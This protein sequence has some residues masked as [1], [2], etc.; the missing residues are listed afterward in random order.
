[1]PDRLLRLGPL[2]CLWL[3]GCA[4][5]LPTEDAPI[6]CN[7]CE[8]WSRPQAPFHIFGNTY[9][10]GTGGLSSILITTSDGLVLLDGGLPQS[11]RQIASSIRR[12]GFD[13]RDVRIIA[14]SHA[15]FDHVG[16]VAALQRFSDAAVITS[17]P[18][19]PTLRRGHLDADDPQHDPVNPTTVFPAVPN[20]QTIADGDVARIGGLAVRGVYTPGHTPGGMSWT[21]QT[22]EQGRCLDVVYADSLSPVAAPGYRFGAG[23]GEKIRQSAARI[24]AMD[25]DI[26]LST[27]DFS[28][29]LHQKLRQGRDAF[30]DP[31][32]CKRYAA[33]TVQR[34]ER[35]LAREAGENPR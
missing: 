12:L 9:Y 35:R 6:D 30:I 28:F 33:N 14:V 16:G 32:G 21:W 1:M 4:A 17:L 25:C 34:L 11:A 23:M 2:V 29:G 20:P 18:A 10:V 19:L 8:H 3:C 27:H 7:D 5:Q 13:P 15:H 31:G 26:F 24:A 22:C